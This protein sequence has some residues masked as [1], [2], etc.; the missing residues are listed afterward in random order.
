MKIMADLIQ[1][2]QS[3]GEIMKVTGAMG[4]ENP[5]VSV[6]QGRNEMCFCGSSLKYKKCHGR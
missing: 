2:G 4:K 3:A 1:K 6:K 5:G